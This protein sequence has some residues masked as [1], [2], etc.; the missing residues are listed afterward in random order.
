MLQRMRAKRPQS[1]QKLTCKH[2]AKM[3]RKIV[4][5]KNNIG[6]RYRIMR[7]ELGEKTKVKIGQ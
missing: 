6:N 7:K 1:C 3:D 4:H 2:Y 5:S